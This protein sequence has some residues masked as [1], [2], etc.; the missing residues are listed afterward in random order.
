MLT[1]LVYVQRVKG[2][3]LPASPATRPAPLWGHYVAHSSLSLTPLHP[4]PCVEG[5]L[6]QHGAQIQPA[7]DD[8]LTSSLCTG[9]GHNGLEQDTL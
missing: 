3:P 5:L 6:Y 2:E 1:T 7:M 4:L 8:T 9:T